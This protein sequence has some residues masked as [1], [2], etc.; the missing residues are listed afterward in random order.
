MYVM[1]GRAI[2]MKCLNGYSSKSDK[3]TYVLLSYQATI[4]PLNY[5]ITSFPLHLLVLS[6]YYY[7]GL[8][9]TN[10]TIQCT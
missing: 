9:K 10:F 4:V 6:I 7:Y 1:L 5:V 3:L 8:F 2:K